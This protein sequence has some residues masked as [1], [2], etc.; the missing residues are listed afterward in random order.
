MRTFLD[1]RTEKQTNRQTMESQGPLLV[2]GTNREK[3]RL[4][5]LG[6]TVPQKF[7][8]V[9][10]IKVNRLIYV[11]YISLQYCPFKG[12]LKSRDRNW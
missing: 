9:P 10:Y 3:H 8:G 2:R 4:C 12:G 6:S 7:I 5:A 1:L 11:S